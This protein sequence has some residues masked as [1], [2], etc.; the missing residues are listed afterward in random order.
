MDLGFL[1]DV[2][3]RMDQA[4]FRMVIAFA[5]QIYKAFPIG[6][7][8][9]HVGLVICSSS[10]RVVFNLNTYSNV[11]QVDAA[12][13]RVRNSAGSL[14]LDVGF[15]VAQT[16]LFARTARRGIPN[17]LIVLTNGYPARGTR[18]ISAA[19]SARISGILVFAIGTKAVVPQ[20]MLNAMATTPR[21]TARVSQANGLPK[22]IRPVISR[23]GQGIC[24]VCL[25]LSPIRECYVLMLFVI[26]FH[27]ILSFSC[28][29]SRSSR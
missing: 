27:C 26:A 14:N 15:R 24:F 4:S 9:T 6:R 8:D 25:N 13:S 12:F 10:A 22:K 1:I 18:Y 17:V 28:Q 29:T 21:F 7:A 2:S 5:K 20:Q 16:Q 23:I 19:G 3:S 11:R